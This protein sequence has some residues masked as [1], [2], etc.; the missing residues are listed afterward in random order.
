MSGDGVPGGDAG[1][2]R[3]EYR[4]VTRAPGRSRFRFVPFTGA[5]SGDRAR[6]ERRIETAE[7]ESP[8][9]QFRIESRTVTTITSP[10]EQT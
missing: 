10:W 8:G 6:L 2:T 9:H 5:T 3:V 1:R 4:I 7:A